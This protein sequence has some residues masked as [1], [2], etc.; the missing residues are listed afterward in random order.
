MTSISGH[1]I[2]SQ[3]MVGG[4]DGAAASD[5][6]LAW[7][8]EEAVRRDLTLHC[9]GASER[10]VPFP[11]DE[12]VLPHHFSFGSPDRTAELVADAV[13]TAQRASPRL[14]VTSQVV[15]GFAAATLVALSVHADTIVIGNRGHGV[16]AAALMGSVATQVTTHA[17]CP[18]VVV[19]EPEPMPSGLDGVVIGVDTGSTSKP[20]LAYA[21]QQ[22]SDRGCRLDVVH[23]WWSTVP[24]GLT[25][26]VRRDQVTRQE[27]GLAKML[28]GWT[29]KYP[30]VAVHR[31]LPIGPTVNTLVEESLQSQ[32]LVVGS[33]G[34]GGF[35]RLL[36][37]SVGQGVL[38]HARCPV[39]VVPT[40]TLEDRARS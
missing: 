12:L 9:F 17:R 28:A 6:A 5:E 36:L 15:A 32:L 19:R 14:E 34:R 31:H 33:R 1:S 37:G 2:G 20:A 10:E 24:T 30:D 27:V 7:A 11:G 40:G 26:D 39:A 22:A 4:I 29:E 35:R 21:F 16:L 8:T 23:V 13:A 25:D 3:G 38:Q 18:V